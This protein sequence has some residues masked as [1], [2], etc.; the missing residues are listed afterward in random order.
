V[1]RACVAPAIPL[2]LVSLLSC[3]EKAE[4]VSPGTAGFAQQ[5][6]EFCLPDPTGKTHTEES[7]SEDGVVFVVTAPILSQSDAQ[8]GWAKLLMDAKAGAKAQLVMLEDMEPSNFKSTARSRMKDSFEPGKEP[9]VL[10]DE[11][12]KVRDSF[13]VTEELTAVLVYDRHGK[14]IHAESG[15]PSGERASVVWQKAKG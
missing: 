4:E 6:P 13:K 1:Q 7:V 8:E 12:G 9:L 10:L 5:L 2:F 14:L 3:S 11:S 15:E